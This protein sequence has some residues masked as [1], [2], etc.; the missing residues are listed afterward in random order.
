LIGSV[1][2][3]TDGETTSR[4]PAEHLSRSHCSWLLP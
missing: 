2:A 4:R 1:A 3:N